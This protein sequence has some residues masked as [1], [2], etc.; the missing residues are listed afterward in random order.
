MP[1]VPLPEGSFIHDSPAL[2]GRRVTPSFRSADL[3]S[4]PAAQIPGKMLRPIP[5]SGHVRSTAHAFV[6]PH[7]L[8]L[9]VGRLIYSSFLSDQREISGAAEGDRQSGGC[10][11]D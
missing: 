8:P 10:A 7:F 11:A 5:R 2:L 9:C 6:C 3:L 1:Q 4:L